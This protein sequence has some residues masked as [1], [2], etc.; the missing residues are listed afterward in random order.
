MYNNINIRRL[1]EDLK[2]LE[3]SRRW[4][5]GLVE[6]L[7]NFISKSDDYDLFRVNPLRFANQNNISETDGIDLFLWATK[8][9]LFEMNWELLC[10]ACGD[11]IKSF[12]HLN[13]MQ[14]KIFC[15][16]CQCDRVAS[17]DDWI[18]VTFTVNP[19]IRQIK[20]HQPEDLS[21]DE[22]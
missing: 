12:K 5:S 10:P 11:H 9:N 20:F 16:L 2:T 4:S 14:D 18:Q 21:I 13:T 22:I 3:K 8:L 17:L 6:K 1:K 19:K 7:D 15:S